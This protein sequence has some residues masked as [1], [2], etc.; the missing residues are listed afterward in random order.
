MIILHAADEKFLRTCGLKIILMKKI[1][2]IIASAFLATEQSVAQTSMAKCDTA[3]SGIFSRNNVEQQWVWKADKKIKIKTFV[4]VNEYDGYGCISK[5]IFPD[6]S[7]QKG[8]YGVMEWRFDEKGN[9]SNF[10][11]GKIDPDSAQRVSYSE[12][13][14][15]NSTGTLSHVETEKY[16]SDYSQIMEKWDFTYSDKGEKRG[17]SYTLLRVRKDTITYDQSTFSGNG[18]LLERT[19]HRYFPKGFSDYT[20]YNAKNIR[21]ESMSYEKGVVKTHPIHSYQFDAQGNITEENVTDVVSKT[22]EKRKY[23]K[24]QMVIAKYNSKGKLL[25][26]NTQPIPAAAMMVSL[27]EP[28]ASQSIRK[29]DSNSTK[30]MTAKNKTDKKKNKI[31]EYYSGQ[32]LSCSEIYNSKG[33]LT[34]KNTAADGFTLQYEYVFY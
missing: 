28:P 12:K 33:L 32:K 10:S 23:E 29:Q 1:F 2:F 7:G 30:G 6:P 15:Y 22:K 34:E 20:K 17:T 26:T 18:T 13:Y 11:Q 19:V 31:T 8:T 25:S 24:N 4:A 16:E 27:P 5:T 3:E 14:L 21:I 9:L